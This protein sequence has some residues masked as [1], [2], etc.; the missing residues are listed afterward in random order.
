[1]FGYYQEL[2]GIWGKLYNYTAA[3][4]EVGVVLPLHLRHHFCFFTVMPFVDMIIA[5]ALQLEKEVAARN[6]KDFGEWAN[7]LSL[8]VPS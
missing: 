7:M 8:G 5:A 4:G 1:M 6:K 2:A 3:L